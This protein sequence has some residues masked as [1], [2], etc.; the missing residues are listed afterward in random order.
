MAAAKDYY[1]VLGV[2]DKATAAD[3]KKAYRRLAKQ[4][5]PDANPDDQQAAERFKEISEAYSVLSDDEKRKQYDTMRRLGAFSRGAQN[6]WSGR[7]GR[8]GAAGPRAEDVDFGGFPGFGGLGD[9]FS[10][11]FGKG[12]QDAAPE[13]IE[14]VAE[15]PFDTA[16]LGGKVPVTVSVTEACSTCGGSGAAPG[17]SVNTCGECQGRGTVTFGQ[18]GFAVT[19]PCPA[20]R[21]RGKVASSPCGTC[22]GDGEAAQSKRLMVTVP[23]GTEDG[24]RVRLKGQ[25][26]RSPGGAGAGDLLV[27]FHVTPDR[28]FS[29]DGLDIHCTIPVNVAQAMLGTKIKVRTIHGGKV[30]LTVP[31]GTQPGRKFRLAGQ[32]IEKGD[33]R[34]DQYVRIDV[35]IPESLAPE[36]AELFKEFADRIGL[37]H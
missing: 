21:G 29:R 35:E 27:T 24:Q 17:A 5:H 32:G 25:G 37:R 18:G 30:V 13:P 14:T 34:G 12:K 10:S 22:R 9:L 28:F 23:A 1:Q 15:V 31:A 7:G 8:P 11:I 3:I 19:R 36:Q 2:A 4:Y 6:A 16:A 26:Q 33:K 20:C